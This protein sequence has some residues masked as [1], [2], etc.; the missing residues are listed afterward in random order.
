MFCLEYFLLR[1]HFPVSY[2]LAEIADQADFPFIFKQQLNLSS[3]STQ[4]YK[5][6]TKTKL[7]SS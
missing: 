1:K 4:R 2:Q 3:C 6:I 7:L 5:S